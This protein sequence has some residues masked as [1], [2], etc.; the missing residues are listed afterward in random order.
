MK[1]KTEREIMIE[2][3]DSRGFSPTLT[4]RAKRGLTS[5]D[6]VRMV[7]GD[8]NHR[9]KTMAVWGYSEEEALILMNQAIEVWRDER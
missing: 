4:E 8:L 9:L 5:A 6:I 7:T 2:T 1:E 3:M